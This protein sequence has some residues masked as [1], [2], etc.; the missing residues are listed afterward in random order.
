MSKGDEDT[1]IEYTTGI[2]W[3]GS[4]R[5]KKMKAIQKVPDVHDMVYLPLFYAHHDR[6]VI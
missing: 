1:I 4:F 6:Y 5:K 2:I 3:M